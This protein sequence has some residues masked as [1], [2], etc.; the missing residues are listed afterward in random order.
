M[1][2][3]E[4]DSE[5]N[6]DVLGAFNTKEEAEAYARSYADN[7]VEDTLTSTEPNY[8]DFYNFFFETDDQWIKFRLKEV[9]FSPAPLESSKRIYTVNLEYH[10]SI[11]LDIKAKSAEEAKEKAIDRW[12]ENRDSQYDEDGISATVEEKE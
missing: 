7:E 1:Y 10:D 11:T 9:A 6:F 12:V 5:Y 8:K 3:L 2:I 4:V